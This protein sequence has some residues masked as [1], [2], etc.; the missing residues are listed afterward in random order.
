MTGSALPTEA[1]RTPFRLELDL[2]GSREVP[3]EARYG[4]HALRAEENF[5]RPGARRL[6][7]IPELCR[8][9]GMVKLSAARANLQAA[10]I[11]ETVAG[12]IIEAAEDLIADRAELRRE[13]IVPV[14]QGGAGTSSNMNVNEALANRALELLGH[15]PGQYEYC[16]PNDHVNR[17]QSTNDVY[18]T[19]LR[20]ALLMRSDAVILSATEL[21]AELRRTAR[22]HSGMR[23]LGRTQLQDA[24]AMDV[25]EEFEAWAD[26][27]ARARA[28][29][30]TAH[31]ALLEVNL[32]GTAIGNGLTASAEYRALVVPLL[33]GVSGYS[34]RAAP[35]GISATTETTA[36]LG[37]S[38]AL[39]ALAVALAKIA[40]DLRLL[41]SGPR[42]GLAEITLPPVQGGSSMMPGKVNPVI[43]EWVNQLSFRVRGSDVTVTAALDAGQLQLNAM[44]PLVADE[45][46]ASQEDLRCGMDGLRTR[47]IQ[48]I[49]V[50]H[51]RTAELAR[52][53][54]GELTQ[55]AATQGYVSATRLAQ[56]LGTAATSRDK[57]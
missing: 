45:L 57:E 19:A 36:L 27:V 26:H 15:E 18:P 20:L 51:A 13:L 42:G 6:G 38:G 9:F 24:I 25:E 55:L 3:A 14:V 40:N 10:V 50:D 16:H 11:P 37:Y 4:V 30:L 17:S 8:A 54:I 29:L 39:R 21:E 23:K 2:V 34:L 56:G 46:L 12:A 41:T 22:R 44:L 1:T 47:C 5:A 32:G 33:A 43:A 48:G 52:H 49:V 35:R 7:D 53:D 28:A 31:D